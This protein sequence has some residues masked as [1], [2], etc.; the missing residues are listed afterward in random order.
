MSLKTAL[1]RLRLSYPHFRLIKKLKARTGGWLARFLYIIK[2]RVF[3]LSI[4]L[5]IALLLIPIGLE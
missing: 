3:I 4:G 5:L 2:K 1:A